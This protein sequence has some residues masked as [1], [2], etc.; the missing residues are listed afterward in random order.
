MLAVI[1]YF[2]VVKGLSPAAQAEWHRLAG[3]LGKLRVLTNLDRGALATYCSAY[4]LWAEAIEAI[5]KFG[6]MVKSPTGF[7]IWWTKGF[8]KVL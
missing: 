2:H 5:Q 8:V 3:E 7:P 4:A 6:V 1:G